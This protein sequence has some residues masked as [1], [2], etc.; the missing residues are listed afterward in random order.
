MSVKGIVPDFDNEGSLR[1]FYEP[2]LTSVSAVTGNGSQNY[3]Q[4]PLNC[5]QTKIM[6]STS[7]LDPE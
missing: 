7:S 4:L 2:L 5:T 6:E 3:L 1:L